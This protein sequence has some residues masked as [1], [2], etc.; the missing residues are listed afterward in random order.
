MKPIHILRWAPAD[1]VNDPAVK[2]ALAKRDFVASTFYP[3]F[4]FHAFIQGGEL[5]ANPV[6]LGAIVGLRPGDVERALE[7]WIEQGKI[8]ESGGK[9]YHDRVRRDIAAE[10]EFRQEQAEKGKLGGRPAKAEPLPNQKP[11]V[12]DRK[13][14]PDPYPL[15]APTPSAV[16]GSSDEPSFDRDAWLRRG[17][18]SI[19]LLSGLTGQE[20]ELIA[21]EGSSYARHDGT[22]VGGK[23]DIRGLTQDRLVKTVLDL[24]ASLKAEQSKN[25]KAA[26]Q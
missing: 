10:L 25:A 22:V 1:Y 14:P 2:L 9:L 6:L 15:P 5:P 4:L 8:K 13:S 20:P 23:S 24:E 12:F 19:R 18:A 11:V 16:A 17:W 3:L 26:G 21:M 7:F